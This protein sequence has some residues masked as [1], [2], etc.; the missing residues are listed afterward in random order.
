M[1]EEEPL[2]PSKIIDYSRTT[3]NNEMG[4]TEVSSL[5]EITINDK[6]NG[7]VKTE[8]TLKGDINSIE[9]I[10]I[11]KSILQFYSGDTIEI[12]DVK[13]GSIRLIVEGSQE[14]I[15]RLAERI[16]SGEVREVD[17][18]P[19][20]D[21]KILSESSDDY[22]I[23]G[24][25]DS[26]KV[27]DAPEDSLIFDYNNKNNSSDN[28]LISGRDG[29]DTLTGTTTVSWQDDFDEV[30][31]VTNYGNKNAFMSEESMQDENDNYLL[32]ANL[33]IVKAYKT[34]FTQEPIDNYLVPSSDN[35]P[36]E[37]VIPSNDYSMPKSTEIEVENSI[38]IFNLDSPH[39]I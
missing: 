18:F 21:I 15:K 6:Q 24:D 23:Y 27:L 7:I 26:Y 38:D 17:G 1:P 9:N 25:K 32:N 28:N 19:V 20:K 10:K 3:N 13:E 8:I 29:E 11:L 34:D 12:T 31:I 5:R 37:T 2:E 30:D 35:S 33:D 36:P 22:L 16:Q 14:D 4:Q 39:Q